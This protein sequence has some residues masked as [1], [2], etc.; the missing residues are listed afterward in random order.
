MDLSI[1]LTGFLYSSNGTSLDRT[2]L[3]PMGPGTLLDTIMKEISKHNLEVDIDAQITHQLVKDL[4][5]FYRTRKSVP[6]LSRARHWPLSDTLVYP[7]HFILYF[8]EIFH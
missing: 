8:A 1:L 4:P 5:A 2:G 3:Q 7:P 6:V